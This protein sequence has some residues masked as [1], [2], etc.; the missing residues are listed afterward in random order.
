MSI[1]E[2]REKTGLSQKMFAQKYRIPLQTLK[3][4]ESS[5]DSKSHRNPPEYVEFLLAETI[6]YSAG[7]KYRNTNQKSLINEHNSSRKVIHTIRTAKDSQGNARLWMRYIAK[8]FE[9]HTPP[10]SSSELEFLLDGDDL[11]L[12]QKCIL[13]S[14]YQNGSPTNQYIIQLGRKCDT[15]FATRLIEKSKKNVK[16]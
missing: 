4:W 13:K 10:L 2:I 1:K 16:Q 5:V 3:Q 9:D 15:S 12:S 7:D 14:A 11:T 6:R 8:Q